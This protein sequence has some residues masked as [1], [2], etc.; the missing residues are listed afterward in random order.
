MKR[1]IKLMKKQNKDMSKLSKVLGLL[2]SG[3]ILPPEYRDHELSGN[4]KDV[5]ECHIEGDWLLL[6]QKFE[7]RLILS[8]V[9]TGSHTRALRSF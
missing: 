6:Y 7:S 4:L 2:A 1:D 8:A 3:E 9:A 5:R